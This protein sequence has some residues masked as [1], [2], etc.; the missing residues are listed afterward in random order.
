MAKKGDRVRLLS[1]TDTATPLQPGDEGT[2][3]RERT[4]PWGLVLD[5][6]WDSGSTLSLL[7]GQD[8]WVI[9]NE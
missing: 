1:C 2:V 7:E 9:F 6:K 8:Q 4:D 3:V 5:V